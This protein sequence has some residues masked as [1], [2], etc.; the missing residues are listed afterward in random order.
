LT[1]A[2]AYGIFMFLFDDLLA[3]L[4]LLMT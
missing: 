2:A 1:D 3:V 4:R